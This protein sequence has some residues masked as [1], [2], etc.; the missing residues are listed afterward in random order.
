MTQRSDLG[1]NQTLTDSPPDGF[2]GVKLHSNPAEVVEFLRKEKFRE[3]VL[4]E[5]L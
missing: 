4:R 1:P 5:G 3:H 2:H